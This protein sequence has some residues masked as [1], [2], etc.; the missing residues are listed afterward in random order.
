LLIFIGIAPRCGIFLRLRKIKQQRKSRPSKPNRRLY[1]FSLT[2]Y[3]PPKPPLTGNSGTEQI[4]EP[5]MQNAQPLQHNADIETLNRCCLVV[6]GNGHRPDLIDDSLPENFGALAAEAMLP[7][8]RTTALMI[9]ASRHD[10]SRPSPSVFTDEADWFAARILVLQA[11][12]FHLDISLRFM[13]ETAN[14]RAA[15]F[16]AARN[17]PFIPAKIRMS[18]HTRR[19]N[20]LLMMDCAL[21][22]HQEDRGLIENSR[23]LAAKLP[24]L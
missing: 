8:I 20:N 21:P 5:A 6:D 11:R 7:Q 10:F 18:L 4:Q 15:D 12:V 17:L 2:R 24:Q 19:P 3:R 13:L 22:L 1:C 14:R 9:A 16:A 23:R